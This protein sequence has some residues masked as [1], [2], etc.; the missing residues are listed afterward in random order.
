MLWKKSKLL[1]EDGSYKIGTILT[2]SAKTSNDSDLYSMFV[3]ILRYNYT[4]EC[5]DINGD[6]TCLG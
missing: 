6:S 4:I 2:L 5:N 3:W 1:N